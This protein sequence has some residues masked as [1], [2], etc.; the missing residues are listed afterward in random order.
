VA[1][2]DMGKENIKKKNKDLQT[3]VGY[4]SDCWH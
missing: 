4:F 3:S 1:V 2:M